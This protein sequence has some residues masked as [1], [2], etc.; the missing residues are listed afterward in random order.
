MHAEHLDADT[1]ETKKILEAALFMSSAVVRFEELLKLSGNVLHF[2]K[3]MTALMQDYADRDA[4]LEIVESKNGFQMKVK[5]H[6]YEKVTHFASSSELSKSALK[7]LALVA[8]KQPILQSVLIKYRT[9]KAYDDVKLL[10]EKGFLSRQER[11]K[12]FLIRTTQKFLKYFGENPVRFKKQ[13]EEAEQEADV[14]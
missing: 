13:I 3:A 10:E 1:L 14:P 5:E 12:T 11:G 4:A 6:Y 7:T 2:R 9:N 8:Y